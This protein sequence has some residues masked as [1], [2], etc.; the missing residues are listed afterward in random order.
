FAVCSTGH[1][2]P[3]VVEAIIKQTQKFIH[4]CSTNYNY[5][6]ML[7]LTKKLDELAPIKSPTKTYFT[8]SSI[9]AVEP[10]LKLAMYHTKRQKFISFM[11]SFHG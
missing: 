1:C 11:G 6:H 8:N 2:H 4:M 5:H 3:E 10:A 7:D 9:E